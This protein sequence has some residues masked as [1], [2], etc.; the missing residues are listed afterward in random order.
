VI[1]FYRKSPEKKIGFTA[2][3][4]VGNAVARNFAKRRMRAS[5]LAFSEE[6]AEGTYLFVAKKEIGEIPYKTLQKSLNNAFK[7]LGVLLS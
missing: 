2:S 5:F 7:R 1:V 3:K 6:L 4:K